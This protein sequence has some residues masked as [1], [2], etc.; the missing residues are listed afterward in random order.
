MGKRIKKELKK[1]FNKK[2]RANNFRPYVLCFSL[3][4]PR[5]LCELCGYCYLESLY[6]FT[7]YLF[8]KIY[9]YLHEIPPRATLGRNDECESS[10]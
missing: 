7:I 9:R 5:I 8:T 4:S 2:Q 3:C 6:F 10:E 1:E